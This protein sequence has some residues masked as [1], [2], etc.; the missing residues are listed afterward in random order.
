MVL[1]AGGGIGGFM[2]VVR[3]EFVRLPE[4]AAAAARARLGLAASAVLRIAYVAG[5]GDAAGTF[6]HWARGAQDPRVPVVTY[7]SMFYELIDKLGAEAL[8]LTEPA[9]QPAVPDARFRFVQTPRLRPKGFLA[10]HMANF[11]FARAVL[12][13]IARFQPHVVV[14]GTDAPIWVF[15][16]V[17]RR[18]KLVLTAHNTFWPMG[19]RSSSARARVKAFCVGAALAPVAS[20][21]CTSQECARQ[22]AA[23]AGGPERLFVEIPQVAAAFQG[24]GRTRKVARKLLFLGRIEENKGVFDLLAAFASLADEF[25]DLRLDFAGSGAAEAELR[26]RIK[27]LGG[28][29]RVRFLGQL[30]AAGVHA[31]LGQADVLVCPTRSSFHEGLALVV[32]EAAVHGVPSV[33]SSV[34]P[35]KDLMGEACAEFAADDVAGLT[36]ALRRVA[37]APEVY[38]ALRRA[39]AGKGVM[40]RDGTLSWGSQLYRAIMI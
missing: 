5:P 26:L 13:Q 37:A 30:S 17:G 11:R 12:R 16:G 25:A 28:Q 38:A 22:V 32:V 9:G 2:A 8:I 39:V 40:F 10:W 4:G 7:S 6:E 1:I 27:A 31:A 35:A 29:D 24:G 20:A 33:L 15:R 18:V 34:V 36:E 14:V 21:V 19:R 3:E 23:L